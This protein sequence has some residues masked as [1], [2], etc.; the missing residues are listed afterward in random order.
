LLLLGAVALA[1]LAT[2]TRSA[3]AAAP[4]LRSVSTNDTKGNAFTAAA[5]AGETAG[6]VLIAVLQ[7]NGPGTVSAPTGWTLIGSTSFGADATYSYSRVAGSA[8][9]T[10]YTW[11]CSLYANGSIA[12]LD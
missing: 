7:A 8:E 12:I 1:P 4:A 2:V 6:D 11:N 3:H 5:P 10:S 9:P